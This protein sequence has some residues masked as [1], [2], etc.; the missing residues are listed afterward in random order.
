[1]LKSLCLSGE[2]KVHESLRWCWAKQDPG[3]AVGSTWGVT[4]RDVFGIGIVGSGRACRCW[5]SSS[6]TG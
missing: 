1:M 2:G 6:A 3:A 4:S 5:G